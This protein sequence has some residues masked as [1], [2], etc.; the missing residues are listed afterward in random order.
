MNFLLFQAL[1]HMLPIKS[2]NKTLHFPHS[3]SQDH[4][5]STWQSFMMENNFLDRLMREKPDK[6]KNEKISIKK[7]MW[8]QKQFGILAWR[9][10]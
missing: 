10:T 6:A 9:V 5:A 3:T 1:K 2:V 7:K 8:Y 4:F